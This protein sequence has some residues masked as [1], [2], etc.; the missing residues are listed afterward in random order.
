MINHRFTSSTVNMPI[1]ATVQGNIGG[2]KSTLVEYLRSKFNAQNNMR[3]C[4]LQEPVDEWNT[5]KDSNGTTMLE[6]F[7]G[8]QERYAFGFQMMAYISRLALLKRVVEQGYDIIVSER[9]LDTDRHIFAK[10]LYD[11]S[12]IMDVEYQ[13]YLKWFEEF[14]TDFPEEHIIYIKTVP[15]IAHA[16]VQKRSRKGETIPFEYMNKCHQYHEQWI[17]TIHPDK[18]CII[19]GNID[20]TKQPDTFEKWKTQIDGFL[21]LN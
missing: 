14:K 18:V 8:D 2:G 7:Y 16:R 17:K 1:L 19:D 10:M 13:I 12:K 11:D 15:E 6:L 21:K 4:F 3:V 5:V 9:S 20:I